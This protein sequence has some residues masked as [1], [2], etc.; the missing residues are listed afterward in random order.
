ML[1]KQ[2][3]M[4]CVEVTGK[5]SHAKSKRE[6]VVFDNHYICSIGN[7]PCRDLLSYEN[8]ICD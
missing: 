5:R 7:F 4:K 2:L 1:E 8:F 3:G 6:F